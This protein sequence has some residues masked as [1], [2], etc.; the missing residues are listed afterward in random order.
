MAE[1]LARAATEFAAGR[2]VLTDTQNEVTCVVAEM[3]TTWTAAATVS[4]SR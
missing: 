3:P 1:I 4:A 2:K